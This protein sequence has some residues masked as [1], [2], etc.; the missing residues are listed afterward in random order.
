MSELL[1][2]LRE[3]NTVPIHELSEELFKSYG[4]VL[5]G[6]FPELMRYM[7]EYTEIPAEGN[8]YVA[9]IPEMEALSESAYFQDRIYGFMPIEVGYCN[10]RN[11]TYNG[12]EFHKGSEINI[13][14]TDFLLVLGHTWEIGNCH[15]DNKNAKV[16][17]VPKGTAIEMY[18][19]T[20]HLSPIRV[21]DTGFKDVV[22]LP[23]GTN[24]PLPAKLKSRIRAAS[25]EAAR[26]GKLPE[27]TD[28]ETLLLLQKNK[29]VISH[30]DR[31]PLIGQGAFPGIIG[32]NTELKY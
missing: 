1:Q 30:P 8:Q 10:G 22:I 24:T 31:K 16:F 4:R 2:H 25:E 15:Y 19:T 29:W 20:L 11:T 7:E 18:E 13:A 32:E 5:P 17:F 6:Q 21:N 26:T 12:F 9:S 3:V 27:G 23:E 28:P 14:V